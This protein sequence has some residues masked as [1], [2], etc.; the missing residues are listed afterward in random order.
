MA[1]RSD[2]FMLKTEVE[3]FLMSAAMSQ[4]HLPP[5]YLWK[6]FYPRDRLTL[7]YD[8]ILIKVTLELLLTLKL[9]WV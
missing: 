4:K 2:E 8:F 1:G 9:N 3:S 7:K 6:S 5:L